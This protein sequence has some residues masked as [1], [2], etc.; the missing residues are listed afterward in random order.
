MIRRL[1]AVFLVLLALDAAAHPG[2]TAADAGDGRAC[3]RVREAS[4]SS[5]TAADNLLPAA[6]T[7]SGAAQ[8]PVTALF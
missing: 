8:R 4:T 7:S 5:A 2:R 1:L 3:R 6:V